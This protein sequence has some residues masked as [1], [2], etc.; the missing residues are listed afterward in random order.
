[1]QTLNIA[2]NSNKDLKEKLKAE[3]QLKK[4]AKAALRVLRLKLRAKGSWPM[5][6]KASWLQLKS[7]SQP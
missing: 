4:S 5:I 3:E 2:E 7:K 1:M 6:L